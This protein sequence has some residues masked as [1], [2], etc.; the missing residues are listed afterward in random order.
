MALTPRWADPAWVLPAACALAGALAVPPHPVATPLAA[1]VAAALAVL[2]R[3]LWH[4]SRLPALRV[5]EAPR[6]RA[7]RTAAFFALGV[8]IGLVLLAV[9]RLVIEPGLPAIGERIEAAGRLSV[10]RRL[11]IIYVAAVGEELVFRLLL[12]SAVA[13]VL[14]RV[15][16][17]RDG[18]PGPAALWTAN[19][20][21]ALA[22]AAVHLPAWAGIAPGD[23]RVAAW[24]LALNAAAGLVMGHVFARQGIALAM[25]THAGGDC[26][27]QLLGPLLG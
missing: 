20:V 19:A 14:V 2:G 1:A 24:V 12:L 18:G 5:E 21:A 23:Y 15:S 10:W 22:F 6:W 17:S 27:V 4:W 16:R 13:G 26:A 9:I 8:A 7:A 11:L 3:R 25:W